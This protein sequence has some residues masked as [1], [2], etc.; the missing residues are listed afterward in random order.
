MP[1]E[2]P[3]V[4]KT[5][6][7]EEM[8]N[9]D[10][11]PTEI[12]EE[13]E[14]SLLKKDKPCLSDEED[15]NIPQEEIEKAIENEG[16]PHEKPEKIAEDISKYVDEFVATV[17]PEPAREEPLEAI[18]P[19]EEPEKS[20]GEDFPD[21]EVFPIEHLSKDD[22]VSDGDVS[23]GDVREYDVIDKDDVSE[24]S[25][26]VL[27]KDEVSDKDDDDVI[28]KQRDF[29]GGVITE[30]ESTVETMT[31]EKTHSE[32]TVTEITT[33]RY[34]TSPQD[35]PPMTS[36]FPK[37]PKA[38]SSDDE[39]DY[40]II[41]PSDVAKPDEIVKPCEVEIVEGIPDNQP[42]YDEQPTTNDEEP[43]THEDKSIPLLII[44]EEPKRQ[45]T[46]DSDTSD[47]ESSTTESDDE[48]TDSDINKVVSTETMAEAPNQPTETIFGIVDISYEKPQ[49]E[50]IVIVDT[51]VESFVEIREIPEIP[52]KT[53][54]DDDSE[55]D[56]LIVVLP[57]NV[58][59]NEDGPTHD[60]VPTVSDEIPKEDIALLELDI[61]V[62][63]DDEEWTTSSDEEP[64]S[65]DK[66]VPR[67][68]SETTV[69]TLIIEKTSTQMSTTITR[70][71]PTSDESQDS[72][73]DAEVPVTIVPEDDPTSEA[74]PKPQGIT[75]S[76]SL[77]TV[78][79][80]S[81]TKG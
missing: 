9:Q 31:V 54:S 36:E 47:S 15:G 58:P 2:T 18:V 21:V 59:T 20:G 7:A 35:T 25:D 45:P 32:V 75:L 65:K 14:K 44:T 12:T 70:F 62:V 76:N 80:Q 29:P 22:D 28:S 6:L 50:E 53:S 4:D 3:Q 63:P 42:T 13:I 68:T 60:D 73:N 17:L 34:P 48:R 52:R 24:K 43:T 81:T 10:D 74:L 8:L 77:Y 56:V 72:E 64:T 40:V 11:S 67:G 38:S 23:D 61:A 41:I 39:D 19:D 66:R 33:T 5:V 78:I 26:E 57:E 51:T 30:E 71:T 55:K 37:D 1:D 46:S 79:L 49:S 27:P 69:E 16:T